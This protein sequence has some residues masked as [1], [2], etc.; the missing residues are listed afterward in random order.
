MSPQNE[1]YDLLYLHKFPVLE[2]H[3]FVH[4]RFCYDRVF[5]ES[6]IHSLNKYT[7]RNVNFFHTYISD[8]RN[9]LRL[10]SQK[11]VIYIMS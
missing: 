10:K 6:L 3:C 7:W 1:N 4:N 11:R 5:L 2:K 8:D 9:I